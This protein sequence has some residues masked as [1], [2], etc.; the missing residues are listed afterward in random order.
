MCSNKVELST[1]AGPYFTIHGEKVPF[2]MS[3]FSSRNIILH[4][5]KIDNNE[6]ELGI[7]YDMIIGCKLMVQPGLS[8]EFK[9]QVLQWDSATVPM[10]ETISMIGQTDRTSCNMHEVVIH[11]AEPVYTREYT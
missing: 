11:T 8:D 9:R 6:G 7:G 4:H 10:K 5:F 1:S 2:F 3:E